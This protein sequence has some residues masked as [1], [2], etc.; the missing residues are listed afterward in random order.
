[1][2]EQEN[3]ILAGG[4]FLLFATNFI[5]ITFSALLV[6][7]LLGL[8]NTRNRRRFYLGAVAIIIVGSSIIIPLA[9]NYQKFSAGAQF[10][11]S[12]YN[13]A[14][15]VLKLSK[16][17]PIIKHISIQGTGVIITIKPFPTDKVEEQRLK[18]ALEETTGLQVF[19]QSSNGQYDTE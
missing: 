11:S 17:S 10:Q 12:I 13:K 18:I 1:M 14:G 7:F 9:L 16:N 8:K 3:F 19:L 5:G 2:L 15:A 6:F 4:S